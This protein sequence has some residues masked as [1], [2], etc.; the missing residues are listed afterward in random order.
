MRR[1]L[2][3]DGY[4]MAR[5]FKLKNIGLE[6]CEPIEGFACDTAITDSTEL[7]GFAEAIEFSMLMMCK[8]E[9][10]YT[11]KDIFLSILRLTDL[12]DATVS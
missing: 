11:V 3:G 9:I 12:E 8:Y 2:S 4:Q 10:F 7:V 6:P 1:L 5:K